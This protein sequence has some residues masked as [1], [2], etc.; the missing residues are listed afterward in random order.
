[1]RPNEHIL[2]TR[3]TFTIHTASEAKP[4]VAARD[5]IAH[6]DGEREDR[7]PV[8][9]ANTIYL[10]SAFRGRIRVVCIERAESAA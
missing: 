8:I 7:C 1:M 6:Q 2:T 4:S 5:E 9:R 3:A 10:G